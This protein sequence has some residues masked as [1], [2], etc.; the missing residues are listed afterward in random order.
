MDTTKPGA[1]FVSSTDY[2]QDGKW[3]GGA[4]TAGKFTFS[5]AVGTSDLAG[6]VYSLDGAAAQ[7][8]S[9]TGSATV[10]LTPPAD[11]HRTLKVQTKDK[12]GNVSTAVTY[13]FLV[14][15]GAIV[16]PAE[17]RSAPAGSNWS[18]THSRSTHG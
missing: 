9:A 17:E 8:L 3:H 14:G 15:Q 7:T 2:P 1:P 6:Y 12:A 10:T 11:G 13:D 18:W 5:P 4:G 16:Q